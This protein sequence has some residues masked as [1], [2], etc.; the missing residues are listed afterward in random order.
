MQNSNA[1]VLLAQVEKCE[2][3]MFAA[4]SCYYGGSMLGLDRSSQRSRMRGGGGG[5]THRLLTCF[6]NSPHWGLNPGPSVYKTDALPLSYRGTAEN[7]PE[8]DGWAVA[9][10]AKKYKANH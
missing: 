1:A 7:V 6:V 4:R 3:E 8:L 5:P 9:V 2:E 10:H